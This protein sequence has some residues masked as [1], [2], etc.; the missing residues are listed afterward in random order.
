MQKEYISKQ[1]KDD[2]RHALAFSLVFLHFIHRLLL[3]ICQIIVKIFICIN[4][5]EHASLFQYG[6][7][8]GARLKYKKVRLVRWGMRSDTL[9]SLK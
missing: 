2:F 8:T 4:Y 5:P 1:S 6:N 3:H 7:T 9:V